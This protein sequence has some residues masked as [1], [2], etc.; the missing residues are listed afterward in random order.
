MAG[1][2][3]FGTAVVEREIRELLEL[4]PARGVG[5]A[6]DAARRLLPQVGHH[7]HAAA[8]AAERVVHAVDDVRCA[9]GR[10]R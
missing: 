5:A 8:V 7:R 6:D 4:E 9:A 10:P 1:S 2:A 3:Q